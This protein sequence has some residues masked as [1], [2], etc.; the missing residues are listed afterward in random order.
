MWVYICTI[1]WYWDG[2]A[3]PHPQQVGQMYRSSDSQVMTQVGHAMVQVMTGWVTHLGQV[4]T[5]VGHCRLQ[6]MTL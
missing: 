2:S 3:I 5:Q 4:M 6:V 1:L